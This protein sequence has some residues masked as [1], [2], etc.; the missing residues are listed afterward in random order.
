MWTNVTQRALQSL[1]Y[2]TLLA[3]SKYPEIGIPFASLLLEGSSSNDDN[4]VCL[5]AMWCVSG[6][7]RT[8]YSGYGLSQWRDDVTM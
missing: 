4:A 8:D 5:L 6:G 2:E 7:M 3:Y 1:F